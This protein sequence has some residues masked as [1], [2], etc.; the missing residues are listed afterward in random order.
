MYLGT[1]DEEEDAAFF[2]DMA[3][4]QLAGLK[5]KTNFS[6]NKEAVVLMF[7]NRRLLKMIL[8]KNYS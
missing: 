2:Y 1:F 5:A 4:I 3:H 6:Y 8:E 7:Q